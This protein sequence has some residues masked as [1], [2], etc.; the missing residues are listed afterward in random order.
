MKI[1][2]IAAH[3]D[4]EVLGLGATLALHKKRKDEVFVLVCATGQF[5]RNESSIGIQKRKVQCEE[6]CSILGIDKL[7]FLDYPDQTLDL[8]KISE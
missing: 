4:D 3:P 7:E 1:L 6:A 5:S 2:I 8:V